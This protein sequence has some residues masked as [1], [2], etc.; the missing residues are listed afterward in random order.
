MENQFNRRKFVT[1]G[2]VAGCALFISGRLSAINRFNYLQNEIPDPKKLNYCG[3]TC[4]KDCQFLEASVKNDTELKRKAYAT[5][6][7]KE[8]FGVMEFDPVKIF[9]FGCK[10]SNK[11]VG[12]RLQKCDVRNCAIGRNL[13]SCIECKD[14]K[15]CEKDLWKKFPDFKNVVIKMQEVYLETK[16]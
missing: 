6:E 1:V 13:D 8:R 5:W 4:P 7:M 3:Y 9:C 15:E 14:L 10:T 11:P 2:A 12:I 16:S